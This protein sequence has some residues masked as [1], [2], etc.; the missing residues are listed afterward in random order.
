M[1]KALAPIGG[2]AMLDWALD[3]VLSAAVDVVVVAAPPG[4]VDAVEALVA[5]RPDERIRVLAG[6]TT[7]QQSVALALALV[8]DDEVVLVHDAA[9]PL[10]PS[11]LFDDIRAAVVASGGGVVP[12]LTPADTIKQLDGAD[13]VATLDRSRL[14]AVQTPQGFPAGALKRAYTAAAELHTDDAALFAAA[15]SSRRR[16]RRRVQGDDAVGSAPC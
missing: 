7:R 10:T 3:G 11:Q 16:Q 6:G 1:P 9:R 5:R 14:A 12:A 4:S 15:G 8:P 13:V 2:R